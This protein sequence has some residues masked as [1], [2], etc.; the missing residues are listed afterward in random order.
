MSIDDVDNSCFGCL[1]RKGYAN[2]CN[3]DAVS[4]HSSTTPRRS[5][6]PQAL[7]CKP[8]NRSL[9]SSVR[10]S[11]QVKFCSDGTTPFPSAHVGFHALARYIRSL[12]RMERS[13]C[14]LCGDGAR[15]MCM[16]FEVGGLNSS[17]SCSSP[18]SG[19]RLLIRIGWRE[20]G[21]AR[22]SF[23][24]ASISS[25]VGPRAWLGGGGITCLVREPGALWRGA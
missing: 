16:N 3:M 17:S 4:T 18:R 21:I 15:G 14:T 10:P 19:C 7:P 22:D 6:L 1:W 13:F 12:W 25:L 23:L 11:S 9:N 2:R 8:A 20:L 24:S 5:H